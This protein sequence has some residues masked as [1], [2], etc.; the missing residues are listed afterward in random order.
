MSGVCFWGNIVINLVCVWLRNVVRIKNSFVLLGKL[1]KNY[2][3]KQQFLSLILSLNL[4][5]FQM[6]GA[7]VVNL[8]SKQLLFKITGNKQL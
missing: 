5:P 7:N 2:I 1:R 3:E 4:E 6:V 8:K